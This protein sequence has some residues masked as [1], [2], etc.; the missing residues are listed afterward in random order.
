MPN[1]HFANF[2]I[3]IRG[4]EIPYSAT[5]EYQQRTAESHFD[6]DIT[7]PMWQ[8]CLDLLGDLAEPAG[9]E[10]IVEVGSLLF[11]SLIRDQIRDLWINARTDLEA[12]KINGLRIRLALQPPAVASLP[13]ESLCD[14]DRNE[15]FAANGQTPLVRVENLLHQVKPSRALQTELPIRI[16]LAIPDDP[17]GQI[18]A[19]SEIEQ[20]E[21]T[22]A[23]IG[24]NNVRLSILQGQFNVIDLRRKIER[25]KTQ[26]VHLIS[27]G[28]PEGILL[29]QRGK[30]TW[31]TPDA[32]HTTLQRTNSVR[33]VFLNACLAGSSSERGPFTTVGPQLLQTGIPAVIA[34]QFEIPD[35]DAAEFAHYVYDELINGP[36]PGAIDAAVGY[37]RSNLYAL[38]PESF[39]Y[40]VPVLW[41]N[42]EEGVIFSIPEKV[43][44]ISQTFTEVPKPARRSSL[45][46]TSKPEVE[47]AD[48]FDMAA[49]EHWTHELTQFDINQLPAALRVIRGDWSLTLDNLQGVLHQLR[50]LQGQNSKAAFRSDVYARKQAEIRTLQTKLQH[51][52]PLVRQH[53][54]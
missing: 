51:L 50:T 31:V 22:F 52:E 13:W 41:L 47:F 28:K 8:Q 27:H 30:P 11:H 49:I 42:A 14:P 40:G 6:Q 33:L 32:L 46:L 3:T 7:L 16:L 20:I 2:D 12:E 53:L 19:A 24:P 5:A 18:N 26:I 37:A 35:E 15:M 48:L 39:S 1:T 36:Y 17:S 9:H 38:D 54:G 43:P 45:S 23:S 10:L 4:T 34:M 29:W 44:E 25:E 21:K